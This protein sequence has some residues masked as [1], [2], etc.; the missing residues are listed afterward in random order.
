MKISSLTRSY[1]CGSGSDRLL[2]VVE[3]PIRPKL[4][5]WATFSMFLRELFEQKKAALAAKKPVA[6]KKAKAQK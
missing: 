6:G 5:W 2:V 4:G 3:P 1:I